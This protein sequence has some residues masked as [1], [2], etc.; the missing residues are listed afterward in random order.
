MPGINTT[1]AW[2]AIHKFKLF[3]YQKDAIIQM[4][5]NEKKGHG[6]LLCD[7]PGLGKTIQMMSIMFANPKKTLI[8]LPLSLIDQWISELEKVFRKEDINNCHKNTFDPLHVS[9]VTIISYNT[10]IGKQQ[11]SISN[12]Y[13]GRIIIDECHFL[14]NPKGKISMTVKEVAQ[15][16]IVWGI[17]GTPVQNCKKD[18]ETLKSCIGLEHIDID[19]F[20]ENNFVIRRKKTQVSHQ[21]KALELPKMTVKNEEVMFTDDEEKMYKLLKHDGG[22]MKNICNLMVRR[23]NYLKTKAFMQGNQSSESYIHRLPDE[24]IH[25]ILRFTQLDLKSYVEY[26][27]DFNSSSNYM[28]L[29]MFMR[30]RQFI[31]NPQIAL[32]SWKRNLIKNS[33]FD[34]NAKKI[35]NDFNHIYNQSSK[36]K[37]MMDI[38]SAIPKN[39]KIIIFCQWKDEIDDIYKN[40]NQDEIVGIINGSVK[41]NERTEIINDKSKR[42]LIIQIRSG[43][44]GLNLQDYNN[45]III[46]PD[47]NPC[48][49]IQAYARAH[50]IGQNKEVKIWKLI[51]KSKYCETPDQ[52]IMAKQ[53]EKRH[54]IGKILNDD[55]FINPE[56]LYKTNLSIK[57]MKY[58]IT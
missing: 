53:D 7:E 39:E 3:P 45:I 57:E 56:Y 1:F 35:C 16:K 29:A 52:Y 55:E 49:E 43:N 50:R 6:G 44:Y 4:I 48:N 28:V 10:L 12:Y 40:I 47:W 36:I 54:I 15:S 26:G 58:L 25:H 23:N 8:I 31:I 27:S 24:L 9:K 30:L 34:S 38:I 20:M 22:N 17:S 2:M 19:M 37:R 41:P 14:K 5:N 33:S 11:R 42:I 18:I 51:S 32:N 21:N 46:N 13:W